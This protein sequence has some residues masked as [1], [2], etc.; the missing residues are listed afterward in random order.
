MLCFFITPSVCLHARPPL[1]AHSSCFSLVVSDMLT[2]W[3]RV[4]D[5]EEL[6]ALVN[7]LHSRGIREKGL[8]RQIQKYLEMIPQV[9]TKHRDGKWREQ[10]RAHSQKIIFCCRR[11]SLMILEYTSSAVLFIIDAHEYPGVFGFYR[12]RASLHG[13]VCVCSPPLC[14]CLNVSLLFAQWP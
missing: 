6:R 5:V 8:Q 2:G 7:A 4:S 10:A 1:L 13:C 3:W 11:M 12:T 9:C 14:R